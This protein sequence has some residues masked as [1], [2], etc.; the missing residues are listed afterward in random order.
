MAREYEYLLHLL[1]AFIREEEPEIWPDVD[2]E[3]LVSLA[4]IHNIAGILGYLAMNW[5]ICLDEEMNIRLRGCCMKT[6]MRYADRGAM[7][8]N[9]SRKL[10]EQEIDHILMKGYI[11][12]AFFP[13]PELRTFGDVDVVIRIEDRRRCD[14]LM[15][16]WGYQIKADWEP[17]YSYT[18]NREY[19]EI[20]SQ[21]MEVDLSKKVKYREYFGDP[22]E[23][24][25]PIG[26]HC[27]QLEPE[28][29]LLYMLIHIAKHITGS[30]AGIRM[31]LDVAAFIRHYGDGLDWAWFARELEKL[32]LGDFANTVLTLV[33]E[34]F[35]VTSPIALKPI[36]EGVL[37][38]LIRFT[39]A[40]GTFGQIGRD[41]GVLSMTAQSREDGVVS[42]AG[43]IVKR[44][45]PSAASIQG[46]YTYLQKRPWLL[47]IAWVHRMVKTRD[48]WKG[49]TQEVQ[50]ILSADMEKVR[51]RNQLYRKIGL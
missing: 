22:W 15:R 17:V 10:A 3:K 11:L 48:S 16:E 49:H 47:P 39:L 32:A 8:D 13:V 44:L 14:T 23:H 45:F 43:T 28:Y 35:G 30:G 37:P 33:Q 38:E 5:P 7:A 29:H 51:E 21:L 24:A 41:S 26:A 4:G 2:W 25:V 40:G 18:K 19:Y 50:N 27:Y 46:R 42:R 20:H 6:L 12:R 34:C 31:Y 36:G 9:F 1:G